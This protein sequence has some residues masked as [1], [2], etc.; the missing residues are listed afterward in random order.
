MW[1]S[2]VSSAKENDRHDILKY[3]LKVVLDTIALTPYLSK[4]NRLLVSITLNVF[5][6][7]FCS[8]PVIKRNAIFQQLH[9]Y[10]SEDNN[11]TKTEF[12]NRFTDNDPGLDAIAHGLFLE[13]GVNSDGT[14]THQDFDQYFMKLDTNRKNANNTN[15]HLFSSWHTLVEI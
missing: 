11:I 12:T 5:C 6:L 13:I 8:Y 14:I 7:A 2:P 1:F 10:L 15:N 4:N 3:F 9:D